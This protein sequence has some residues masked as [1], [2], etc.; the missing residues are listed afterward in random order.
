MSFKKYY[1]YCFVVI[2]NLKLFVFFLGSGG[3]GRGGGERVMWL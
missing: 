3:G 1:G 2:D